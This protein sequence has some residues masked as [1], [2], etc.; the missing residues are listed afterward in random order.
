MKIF[1]KMHAFDITWSNARLVQAIKKNRQTFTERV[2]LISAL[3]D[4]RDESDQRGQDL[5]KYAD[6]LCLGARHDG[7][8]EGSSARDTYIPVEKSCTFAIF[9]GYIRS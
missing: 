2:S 9:R 8:E 1:D 7:L 5:W 6:S 3:S 4:L